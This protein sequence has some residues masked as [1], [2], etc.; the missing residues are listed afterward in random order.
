[1][2]GQCQRAGRAFLEMTL[3]LKPQQ[4]ECE[5]GELGEEYLVHMTS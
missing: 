3:K 5:P 2:G 4:G 1:M